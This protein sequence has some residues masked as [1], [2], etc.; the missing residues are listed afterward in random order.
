MDQRRTSQSGILKVAQAIRDA[1]QIVSVLIEDKKW[2]SWKGPG[3]KLI[4]IA[5]KKELLAWTI[6]HEL[7]DCDGSAVLLT[8][9]TTSKL[10]QDAVNLVRSRPY[11]YKTRPNFKFSPFSIEWDWNDTERTNAVCAQLELPAMCDLQSIAG[12]VGVNYRPSLDTGTCTNA[13]DSSGYRRASVSTANS[14][15]MVAEAVR[16]VRR[17]GGRRTPTRAA[18]SIQRAKNRE[19]QNVIVLWPYSVTGSDERM[20]RLLY[21]AVTR[22]QKKCVVIA[23][24][25][26]RLSKPP[27]APRIESKKS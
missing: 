27:F 23:L 16:D 12:P 8:P 17:F 19:F 2:S 22:S 25:K 4:E 11:G 6:S 15:P 5:A 7:K 14:K 13:T 3:F 21:N 24:G 26:D 1:Q 10:V 20:R 9:D 18:M